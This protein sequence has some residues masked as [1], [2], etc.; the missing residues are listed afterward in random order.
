L[1][2]STYTDAKGRKRWVRNDEIALIVKQLGDYL[3]IGGYPEQ[4]AKRYAQLAHSISRWPES[5]DELAKNDLLSSIPGVGGVITGYIDEI[6]R[7][8]TTAKFD[9]DQYGPPP[10]RSVLELTAI[11][12]LGAKTAKILYQD[13][14]IDSL[15]TLCASVESGELAGVKGIGPKMLD[16]IGLLCKNKN[17]NSK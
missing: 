17:K 8:G 5:I 16:T 12:R 14:K 4:H 7:T 3:I 15:S 10:P 2:K 1:A 9:D 6:I 11:E 13:Y